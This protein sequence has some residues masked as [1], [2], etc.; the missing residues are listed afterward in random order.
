MKAVIAIVRP[1]FVRS[2]LLAVALLGATFTSSASVFVSVAFAPPPLP[3][4]AQPICPGPEYIWVPGYWAY[5]PEG[6]YWVPGTWVLAP[7]FG[8]LW[9]PGYWG[10]SG[11]VYLWHPGY[12]GRHVGFYGG[13]DYGFGYFGVG[14][15]GG[16]WDRG[17]FYYNTAVNNVNVNIV[18]TTYNRPVAH[19]AGV[20]HVS[21]N[22]PGGVSAR[23]SAEERLAERDAHRAATPLQVRHERL[24]GSNRALLASVNHGSPSLAATPRPAA[25]AQAQASAGTAGRAGRAPN[26]AA[27]RNGRELRAEPNAPHAASPRGNREFRTEHG[28]PRA[29]AGPSQTERMPA[30][31]RHART[32]PQIQKQPAPERQVERH[33]Q[34]APRMQSQPAP[35][36]HAQSA[37][38]FRAQEAPRMQNPPAPE[39]HVERHAQSAP[40][41]RAQEAPRMQSTPAPERPARTAPQI[42]SQPA[43]ERHAQNMPRPQSA[44]ASE[45]HAQ[46]PPRMQSQPAPERQAQSAPRPQGQPHESRGGGE[47]RG[48]ERH[49]Q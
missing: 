27:P 36:R 16:Y 40:Q 7:F 32:A 45:F 17:G 22:G 46:N 28:G 13:I 30:P 3:V 12:W 4:Y 19:S 26:E 33:A 43:P 21:F 8:A 2:L 38:Q 10:W 35:E 15:A 14:Y 23:P 5:G 24:A 11:A 34:G 49:G 18:R 1:R 6:Y 37:P 48:E 20:T 39:R 9:T 44:P 25:F 41:F 42:Q 29:N 47:K 31:E